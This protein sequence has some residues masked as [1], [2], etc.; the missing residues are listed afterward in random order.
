MINLLGIYSK[1]IHHHQHHQLLRGDP[2]KITKH[3]N[4]KDG[5][6]RARNRHEGYTVHLTF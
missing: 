3:G 6:I 4:S 5:T 1:I 2:L